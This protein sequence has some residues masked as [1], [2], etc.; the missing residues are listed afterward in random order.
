MLSTTF[1]TAGT[2]NKAANRTGKIK[3]YMQLYFLAAGQALTR[4]QVGYD[5]WI[6]ITDV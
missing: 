6:V 2:E 5:V 4:A 3:A 1:H